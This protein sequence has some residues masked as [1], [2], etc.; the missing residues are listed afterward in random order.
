MNFIEKKAQELSKCYARQY[1]HN[2]DLNGDDFVFSNEEIENACN[3]MGEVVLTEVLEWLS[4]VNF[5]Y[6]EEHGY[7]KNDLV[8]KE[9]KKDIGL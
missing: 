4:S 7:V 8:I 6:F 9:L 2:S 5:E 3:V 1:R